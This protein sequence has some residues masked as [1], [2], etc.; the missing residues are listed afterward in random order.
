MRILDLRFRLSIPLTYANI[1]NPQTITV[2]VTDINNDC[3]SQTT[4]D[5]IV[6]LPPVLVAPSPLELCDVNNPGDEME[7]FDLESKTFEISGG[8]ANIIITYHLTQGGCGYWSKRSWR[9][10]M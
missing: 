7:P 5:L 4:L 3:W 10:L 2:V 8:D 1:S 6:N 9:V